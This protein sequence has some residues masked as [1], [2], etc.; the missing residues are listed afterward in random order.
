MFSHIGNVCYKNIVELHKLNI[1]VTRQMNYQEGQLGQRIEVGEAG[2]RVFEGKWVKQRVRAFLEP[3]SFP[4]L[5]F[6]ANR[7]AGRR[8]RGGAARAPHT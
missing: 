3:F 5:A 2:Q 7:M 4:P 6:R 1:S 8:G